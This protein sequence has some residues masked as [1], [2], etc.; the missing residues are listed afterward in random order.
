MR[1]FSLTDWVYSALVCPVCRSPLARN[2]G[3][4]RCTAG[5][6]FD[7]SAKGTLN[8]SPAAGKKHGDDAGMI[9]ALLGM[10]AMFQ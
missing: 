2:G 10:F 5:H 7:L 4:V 6:S 8:L 9:A 1:D 3:S